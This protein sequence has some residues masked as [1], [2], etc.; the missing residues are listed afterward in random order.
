[1]KSGYR[2]LA[3]LIAVEVVVQ[4]TVISFAVFGLFRWI[5]GGGILDKATLASQSGGYP[6]A[7][8]FAVHYVNGQMVIP[9]LAVLLLV[10]SF[11]ANVP[12]GVTRAAT[13]LVLVVVQV[14]LGIVGKGAEGLG[15]A[16]G[17]VALVLFGVAV[18]T[19]RQA[20]VAHPPATRVDAGAVA[21][22]DLA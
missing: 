19:G 22:A 11:F 13:V 14:L 10:V 18:H 7:V 16:H 17:V 8:G 2:I 9:L 1:M 6:G 20:T 12:K 15:A 3:Y 21:G 5:K 4:A